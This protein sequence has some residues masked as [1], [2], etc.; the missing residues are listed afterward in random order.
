MLYPIHSNMRLVSQLKYDMTRSSLNELR[1]LA[2]T[3][4]A[5]A[6]KS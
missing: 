6:G 2:K 4:A 5:L 3:D 1:E